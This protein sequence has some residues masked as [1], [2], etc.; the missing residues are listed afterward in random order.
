[1]QF[2]A[3][4]RVLSYGI[5]IPWLIAIGS[6]LGSN[7]VLANAITATVSEPQQR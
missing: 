3:T 4:I 5:A 2:S 1:M 6:F 7:S